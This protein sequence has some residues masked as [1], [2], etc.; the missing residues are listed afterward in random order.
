MIG[1]NETCCCSELG[2][3]SFFICPPRPANPSLKL[4]QLPQPY[5]HG[6][7][8][9]PPIPLRSSKLSPFCYPFSPS[10]DPFKLSSFWYPLCLSMHLPFTPKRVR[11]VSACYPPQPS[12]PGPVPNPQEL[13]H[14]LRYASTKPG[15]VSK[16]VA[17]LDRR[18][19][20]EAR[21]GRVGNVYARAY[22][23]QPLNHSV[24]RLTSSFT[25]PCRSRSQSTSP[26][27]TSAGGTPP[28]FPPHSSSL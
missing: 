9:S 3:G 26:W 17:E 23:P 16:L 14:L 20:R 2:N 4:D 8:W 1:Q 12:F 7:P 24:R 11:L 18:V 28:N 13:S 6:A 25:G 27:S 15:R 22:G 10:M 5:S 21:R 19:K